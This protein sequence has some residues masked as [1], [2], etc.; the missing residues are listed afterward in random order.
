MTNKKLNRIHLLNAFGCECQVCGYKDS[1][2]ALE[3][4][5]RYPEKK[6][7]EINKFAN[8]NKLTYEQIREIEKCVV[9]CSNCHKKAHIGLLDEEIEEIPEIELFDIMF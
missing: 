7:I 5:H 8:N 6:E 4:H 3:F 1:S 9:L 2:S